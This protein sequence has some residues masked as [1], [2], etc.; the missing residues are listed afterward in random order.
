[1]AVRI[2]AR[3]IRRAGELLQEIE[4]SKGGQPTHNGGGTSRS[5]VARDAGLSDRQKVTALRV[6][7]VPA[8][9]FEAA[10]ESNK[11]PTITEMAERGKGLAAQT[12]G[13][14]RH[15]V[16]DPARVGVSCTYGANGGECGAGGAERGALGALRRW[17]ELP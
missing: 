5:S 13:A 2:R 9:E 4:P 3:A 10:V 14:Q 16:V 8:R 11:P 1:M 15:Q 7:A 6:A 17:K 12:A